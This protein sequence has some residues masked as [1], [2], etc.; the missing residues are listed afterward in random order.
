MKKA[1]YVILASL[2]LAGAFLAGS[3]RA[4]REPE[5]AAPAVAGAGKVLYYVDPMHPAY[6]SDKPGIAP[7]CGMALVPVYEDG[8]TGAADSSV[9]SPPGSVRVSPEKQQLVGLRVTTVERKSSTHALRVLGRVT[10]DE[11][12]VY[13]LNAG[14]EGYFR[15]VSAVATGDHVKKDQLL[16]TFSGPAAALVLQTFILSLGGADR[17]SQNVA[18][19]TV[20]A[21]A[22]AATAWNLQLRVQQLQNLGMSALQIEEVKRTRELPETIKILA[23]ADGFVLARNAS[24]GLKFERGAEWYRIVDL[25]RV[26]ILA[27]VFENDAQ[28]LRPGVRAQVSHPNQRR[29]FPARVA[30]ARPQFDAATRTLKVRLE[31]KNSGFALRPDMFVDV[32]LPITLPP[33]I[34]IPVD[35]VLDSG[36]KKTVFVD[37][38]EGVFEPRPVQTGR[39]LGDRVEI[40]KGLAPGERIVV[41]G[42]F[43][44]DSESRMRQYFDQDPGRHAGT[45]AQAGKEQGAHSH[46]GRQP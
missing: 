26:W 36:L 45:A 24:P 29:T 14:I 43:L 20:D 12:R 8:S 35:A 42:M 23:P 5:A 19:G 40:V 28:Y 1:A 13:K 17:V 33:A 22:T 34:T 18:G 38:G 7:D 3:W 44:L 21:Q 4:H 41:A 2:L 11:T 25:S 9:S 30:E 31:T 10:P 6:K 32:E 37:R 16:A 15:D 27:D 39:R 46:G